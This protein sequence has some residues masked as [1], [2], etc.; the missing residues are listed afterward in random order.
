[1]GEE[2]STLSRTGHVI[3]IVNSPMR[4]VSKMQIEV[5]LSMTEAEHVSLLQ[6]IRDLTPIRNIVQHFN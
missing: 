3:K 4:W 1:M 2:S 6:I 5:A